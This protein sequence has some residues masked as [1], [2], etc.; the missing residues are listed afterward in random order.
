[1]RGVRA[2]MLCFWDAAAMPWCLYMLTCSGQRGA[3]ACHDKPAGAGGGGGGV[4]KGGSVVGADGQGGAPGSPELAAAWQHLLQRCLAVQLPACAMLFR[5]GPARYA[6]AE[7]QELELLAA[8]RAANA[9]AAVHFALLSPFA[10]G[11]PLA[12]LWC[13]RVR[14][15]HW[16]EGT[17]AVFPCAV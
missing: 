16:V 17:E 12:P 3:D 15:L 6:F 1:M 10:S 4:W 11:E 2:Q 8:H 14:Y 5:C 7:A 13:Q 9:V